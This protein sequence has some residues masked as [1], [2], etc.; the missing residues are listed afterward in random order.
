MWIRIRYYPPLLAQSVVIK[1]RRF[2]SNGELDTR[3]TPEE[4]ESVQGG[5]VR[6][7]KGGLF[8]RDGYVVETRVKGAKA[9]KCFE[10]ETEPVEQREFVIAPDHGFG[11]M[12]G[13]GLS[14]TSGPI[15]VGGTVIPGDIHMDCAV[16]V[17]NPDTIDVQ[18]LRHGDLVGRY[19][20]IPAALPD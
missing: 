13:P 19:S 2:K 14:S 18:V 4:K 5:L 15:M 9:G 8:A 3:P 17:A 10:A 1:E 7:M 16:S 11:T 12:S 20:V 6:V